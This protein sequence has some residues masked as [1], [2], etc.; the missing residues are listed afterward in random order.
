MQ[1]NIDNYI[2]DDEISSQIVLANGSKT[3]SLKNSVNDLV[4]NSEIL[5]TCNVSK[6]SWPIGN[7][8]STAQKK[9]SEKFPFVDADPSSLDTMLTPRLKKKESRKKRINFSLTDSNNC[10]IIGIKLANGSNCLRRSIEDID[11]EKLTNLG[12]P[13]VH[14]KNSSK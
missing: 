2:D 10:E 5:D 4:R 11:Q 9:C 3:S 13:S 14:R 12:S 7:E 1:A 6:S 8:I